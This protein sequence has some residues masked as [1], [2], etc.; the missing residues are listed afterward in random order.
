MPGLFRA[1][2]RL[3]SRRPLRRA[4]RSR[5]TS[6]SINGQKIWSSFAD[7]ADWQELLIRTD[8]HAKPHARH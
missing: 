1:R 4:A 5:A 6:S 7:I 8:P 3:R 2:L